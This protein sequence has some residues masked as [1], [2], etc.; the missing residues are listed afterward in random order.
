MGVISRI[1]NDIYIM[2]SCSKNSIVSFFLRTV[3]FTKLL[4]AWFQKSQMMK[5]PISID[6]AINVIQSTCSGNS[7]TMAFILLPQYHSSTSKTV[8]LKNRRLLEDK[9]VGCLD[10]F[11]ISMHYA[12]S[13]HAGDRRKK[14]QQ[15]FLGYQL[16][17]FSMFVPSPNLKFQVLWAWWRE[18]AFAI[19]L[20]N[21][22]T[23]IRKK[24]YNQIN[25]KQIPKL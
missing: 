14:S 3:K 1:T 15:W 8:V 5:G 22:H 23:N 18:K 20:C 12:D 9:L 6:E 17:Q 2:T 7:S 13:G 24:T 21:H 16:V 4:W 10:V 19:H 25:Q 11:E